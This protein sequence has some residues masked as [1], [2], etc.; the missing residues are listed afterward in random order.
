MNRRESMRTS[1]YA[2]VITKS[3]KLRWSILRFIVIS[4][5]AIAY[6]AALGAA[7]NGSTMKLPGGHPSTVSKKGA[8]ATRSPKMIDINSASLKELQTLP[9]I[10]DIE[11]EKIIKGRPYLSKADLVTN[12][13]LPEGVYVSIKRL[14]VAKQQGKPKLNR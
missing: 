12:K 8:A 1:S 2:N 5:G 14:I 10:G 11:A 13:V 4:L 3:Y 7:E 6:V 9:G